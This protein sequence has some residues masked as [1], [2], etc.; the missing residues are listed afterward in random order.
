M[1]RFNYMLI[2]LVCP[3]L[4]ALGEENVLPVSPNKMNVTIRKTAMPELG[5]TRIE[6]ILSS[7]YRK[8]L[9][10]MENWEKVVS[11][12]I[13]GKLKT[14]GG[15]LELN[16]YQKKPNLIKMRLFQ[17]SAQSSLVLAYDGELAW[18]QKDRRAEPEP[19][20]GT[21][22]R[23]F[24]HSARFGS[25]LLY[26]Y[27]E[28]KR[29]R[30]ID[31]V[32]VAGAICHHIRVEL[33]TGYQVDYFIDIRSY[34]E[35]KVVNKDLRSGLSNSIVYKDYIKKSGVPVAKKVESSEEGEWVST[36][37]IDQVKVNTGVM[38]WMFQMPE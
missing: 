11:L 2:L 14:E 34:L 29:I 17:E 10:G 35:I 15:D 28:G 3:A 6:K 32:P 12:N 16:A 9:G 33:D 24:I 20:A 21:E 7:Y 26:P 36:L 23:R 22:A 13:T 4:W 8:G 27:A 1:L 38:P 31:T 18:K 19:M 25:Y 37:L 5:E 30:L